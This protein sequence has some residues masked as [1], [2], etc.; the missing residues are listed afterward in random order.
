[1]SRVAYVDCFSG[2]SGDMLLGALI[3]AGVSPAAIARGLRPLRL[4]PWRWTVSR[5]RR[6]EFM[7]TRV[8]VHSIGGHGNHGALAAVRARAKRAAL[9]PGVARSAE[10][11]FVRLLAAEG[12]VHGRKVR[13]VHLH[14]LEDVD[15][16]VDVYGVVFALHLLGVSRVHA[17]AVTTGTGTVMAHHGELPVPAPGTAELLRGAAGI[18]LT[19]FF[20]SFAAFSIFSSAST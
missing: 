3:D 1:M 6:G 5:V 18:A 16:L 19:A 14:E 8:E 17:S 2:V 20:A 12:A 7:G 13:H 10:R 9:P 15:T 11:V 4:P